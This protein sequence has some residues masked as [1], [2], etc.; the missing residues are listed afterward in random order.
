VAAAE[1]RLRELGFGISRVRHHGTV[2]R[3]E[4]PADDI[5]RAAE[6][7]VRRAIVSSLRELGY[8]YVS[9]DLEGFRSG[10]MNELLGVRAGIMED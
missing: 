7:S 2:A 6:A 1:R 3:V 9:L 4:V 10:S 8:A 5:T